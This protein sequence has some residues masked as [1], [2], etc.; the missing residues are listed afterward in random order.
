MNNLNL[1]NTLLISVFGSGGVLIWVLNHI[2]KKQ[3]LKDT[4]CDDIKIIKEQLVFLQEGL[5]MALENDKVIF[6]ALRSHEIN[7]DSESQEEKMD[8]YFIS[9]FKSN[10]GK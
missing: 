6:K 4:N 7:G 3:D 10:G 1:I 8:N 2:S 9:I 5:V